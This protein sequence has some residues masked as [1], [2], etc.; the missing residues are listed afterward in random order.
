MYLNVFIYNSQEDINYQHIQWDNKRKKSDWKL[1][2]I[3][4]F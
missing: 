2:R 4:V 3:L 1:S